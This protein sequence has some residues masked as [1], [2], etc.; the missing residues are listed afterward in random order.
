MSYEKN[1]SWYG[2]LGNYTLW[3]LMSIFLPL[4]SKVCIV[5]TMVFPVVMDGCEHWAIKKAEHQRTDGFWIVVLEKMC[6]NPLDCQEIKPVSPKGNQPWIFT[7]RTDD[8]AEA[9]CILASWRKEPTHCKRPGCW[10]RLKAVAEAGNRRWVA[11]IASSTQGTQSLSKL[12]EMVKDREKGR[13]QHSD[14]TPNS[15][16]S[17]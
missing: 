15:N 13:T 8:E 2:G 6:E 14:W 9:S 17:E 7:E 5:K 12:W 11:W 16:S 4:S 3:A 10:E 1:S